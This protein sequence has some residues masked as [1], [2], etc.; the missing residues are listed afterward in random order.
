VILESP[1]LELLP[2]PVVHAHFAAAA[3]LAAAYEQ[4]SAA[5]VKV[6]LGERKRPVDAQAGASEHDDPPA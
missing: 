3:A 4:R 1:T 6:G 5:R 2:G